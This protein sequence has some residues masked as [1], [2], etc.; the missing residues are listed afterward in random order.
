[1]LWLFHRAAAGTVGSTKVDI[2]LYACGEQFDDYSARLQAK[3][4]R[5]VNFYGRSDEACLTQILQD[6]IDILLDLAGHTAGNRLA[7]FGAKAA[8]S[9]NLS[10]V[11]RHDW[12]QVDYWVT[13]DTAPTRNDEMT[14]AAKNV[15]DLI[16]VT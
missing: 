5:W 7:L 16:A 8:P 1:M 10:R 13:D 15:G 11:L 14:L 3:A 6:E 4:D 9:S 12:P 2:T